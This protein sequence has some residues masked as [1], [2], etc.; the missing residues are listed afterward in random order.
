[1]LKPLPKFIARLIVKD[2]KCKDWIDKVVMV[3]LYPFMI[4]LGLL[5]TFYIVGHVYYCKWFCRGVE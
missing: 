5:M 1:M 4:I 2:R 3:C